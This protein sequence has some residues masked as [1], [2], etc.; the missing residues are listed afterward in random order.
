MSDIYIAAADV[1]P[2]ADNILTSK[3]TPISKSPGDGALVAA[4]SG[5][6]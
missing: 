5:F 2:S 1:H 4:F 3:I 6:L